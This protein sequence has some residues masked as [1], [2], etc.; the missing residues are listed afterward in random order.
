MKRNLMILAGAALT[1][2][3]AGCSNTALETNVAELSSKVDQLTTEVSS[4]KDQQMTLAN[5]VND[6]KAAAMD[7]SSEAMRANDRIDNIATTYK[8]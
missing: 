4:L 3:L 2:S 5:D 1:L 7:A 8:K 6:A